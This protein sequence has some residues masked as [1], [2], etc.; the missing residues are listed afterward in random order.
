MTR[1]HAASSPQDG[2]TTASK[3]E[4]LKAIGL[5]TDQIIFVD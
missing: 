4:N 3:S 5:R 1:H 2:T